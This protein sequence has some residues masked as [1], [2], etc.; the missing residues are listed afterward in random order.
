MVVVVVVVVFVVFLVHYFPYFF[1]HLLLHNPVKRLS[2]DFS[3]SALISPVAILKATARV[4]GFA[5]RLN[6]C[7]YV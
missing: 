5:L 6:T 1:C 3:I 2:C 4:G 7:T